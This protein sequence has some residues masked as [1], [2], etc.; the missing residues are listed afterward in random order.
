MYRYGVSPTS[1]VQNKSCI[2]KVQPTQQLFQNS[3]Y[4][5]EPTL[6]T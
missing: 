6:R 2:Y 3:T 5:G 4:L 1:L